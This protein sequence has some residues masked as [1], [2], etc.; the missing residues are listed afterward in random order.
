MNKN[1]TLDDLAGPTPQAW[2][3]NARLL[4]VNV[5]FQSAVGIVL[6]FDIVLSGANSQASGYTRILPKKS[7]D[8]SLVAHCFQILGRDTVFV[9]NPWH[10]HNDA[11]NTVSLGAHADYK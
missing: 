10:L 4:L 7:I 2:S 6:Q 9:V 5:A 1:N 3:G 8:A 11:A